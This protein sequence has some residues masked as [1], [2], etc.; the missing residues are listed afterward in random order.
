MELTPAERRLCRFLR[1]LA[2]IFFTGAVAYAAG[3]FLPPLA[4]VFRQLPFVANS[5][6]KVTLLGLLALYAAADVRGRLGLVAIVIAAHAVSITAM[7]GVLALGADTSTTVTIA[8]QV[9][10]MGTV[11]NGAMILDG[12]IA[13]LVLL[14]YLPA[15]T[16]ASHRAPP[17]TPDDPQ[18]LSGGERWFRGSMWIGSAL[19]AAAAVGYELGPFLPGTHAFFV[20]LPFVTNSVVKVATLCFVCAYVA[21][22][23]RH[24]LPL[25]GVLIT[26]HIASAVALLLLLLAPDAPVATLFGGTVPM[27]DLLRNAA[28]LDGGIALAL[29]LLY[30]VAW[31]GR[32]HPR[33]LAPLE[34]RALIA[35]AEVVL[36][37]R[38]EAISARAIAANVDGYIAGIRAHRRWVYHLALVALQLH[39]VLYGKPPLS[40]LDDET[41][42]D[43]LKTHFYRD[44]VS[45][46]IPDFVRQYV[47]AMIRIAKQ[48][49][50][51]GYYNDRRT[52]ASVGYV[53]FEERERFPQLVASGQIPPRHPHPLQ[54]E[55]AQDL[56]RDVVEADACVIGS[57]AGG[58]IVAYRLAERGMRVVVVERGRYVEPRDFSCDEVRMIGLL[59]GDGVFEQ[60]EDFRFTVLQGSCVGGSTVV[61]NAVCFDPPD[62]VLERW[63]SP[64]LAAGLDRRALA[65]HIAAVRELM[66]ITP[67]P[68]Q[69]LNPSGETYLAGAASPMPPG[70]Q[71]QVGP[72]EANISGCV[73]CGYC[74]IG[75]AYGKKLSMLDHVLPLAQRR[76]DGRMRIIS[77]LEITRLFTRSGRRLEVREAMGLTPEGRRITIRANRFVVAA[78]TIASSWLLKQSGIGRAL[79]VGKNMSFNMGAPLTA[80][81]GDRVFNAYDGLQ[82]SHFGIPVNPDRGFVLETWWNP[83]ASQAVNMPGWFEQHFDNMRRYP[84]LMAVGVLV[85]T[86]P[87]ARLVRALTGGPGIVYHPDPEDLHKLGDGLAQVGEML[88][89]V[90][91]RR[92][93]LNTWGYDEFTHPNQLSDV[94]RIVSDPS[95]I[96]LGTGHPQGGNA[97]SEDPARGVVDPRFRVHGYD[98]LYVCDASVFPSSLTVNPQLTV[99]S[100]ADYASDLIV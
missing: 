84:H 97:I 38:N 41:R 75:C 3:P 36:R 70:T 37:G 28:L 73:G 78:G 60:T 40:E 96:T 24:N 76:F 17:V 52:Y 64:D 81:F 22:D 65:K 49:T 33:F 5:V 50:Y 48:L 15:R 8:G 2:A 51:I 63:N 44:V 30:H 31:R 77:E 86:K 10:T 55:R 14:F 56:E 69:Y 85:G 72:V 32:L 7:I 12:A 62:R 58:A 61:N 99:M 16:A 27:R 79:P 26:A 53:P 88:F 13:V 98:N 95:Y 89:A 67:Q 90:G 42:L 87:D 4:A 39:P 82:I 23:V 21:H 91:A 83:P 43:H 80:D 29:V 19:F 74:N 1:I 11:L 18:P 9:M 71:L 45:R 94:Y 100:L 68:P 54:V 47:Q 59:Y 20:E 92:V 46:L 57:G 34:Y 35:V 66:E 93:M 6:V 25:G